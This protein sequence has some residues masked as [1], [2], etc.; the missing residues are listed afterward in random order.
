[1]A[2]MAPSSAA[3]REEASPLPPPPRDNPE[4]KAAGEAKAPQQAADQAPQQA[5]AAPMPLPKPEPKKNPLAFGVMA[6]ADKVVGRRVTWVA[7]PMSSGSDGGG[8][9][10]VFFAKGP[11]AEFSFGYVFLVKESAPYAQSPVRRTLDDLQARYLEGRHQEFRDKQRL[12]EEERNRQ[13]EQTRKATEQLRR[14]SAEGIRKSIE[15]SRR[16]TAEFQKERADRR[17]KAKGPHPPPILVT[18]TGTVARFDTLFLI[19][20]G[21][22]SSVPVLRNVTV[23]PYPQAAEKR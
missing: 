14:G 15:D 3:D 22:S 5:P 13:I 20:Y 8:S 2:L 7:Q 6:E 10:H 1:L 19:G 23:V 11:K 16:R 12:R 4:P 21:Q 18:V 17:A 9:Q